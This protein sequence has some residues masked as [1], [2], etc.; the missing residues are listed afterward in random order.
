MLSLL[1]FILNLKMY[2]IICLAKSDS[3][4]NEIAANNLPNTELPS[5]VILLTNMVIDDDK[6]PMYILFK[7]LLNVIIII[8]W[9]W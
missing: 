4:E 6:Y 7:F 3:K 8:G 2:F 5:K 1:L 9:T